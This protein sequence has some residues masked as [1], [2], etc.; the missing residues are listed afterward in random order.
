MQLNNFK[1]LV[2]SV[3]VI[4]YYFYQVCIDDNPF[5]YLHYSN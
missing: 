1:S 5:L 3:D 4:C 2:N